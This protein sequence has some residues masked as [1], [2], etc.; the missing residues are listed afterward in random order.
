MC[1]LRG[2]RVLLL[3]LLLLRK[4]RW[5]LGLLGAMIACLGRAG[6]VVLRGVRLG[7]RVVGS[8]CLCRMIRSERSL[9]LAGTG[10][11]RDCCWVVSR[12]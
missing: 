6:V 10:I 9:L 12:L 3:L 5:G 11:M 8:G 7:V 4:V 2:G 1:T